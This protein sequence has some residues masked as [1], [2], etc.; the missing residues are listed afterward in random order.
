M[1]HVELTFD[2]L[3]EAVRRLPASQKEEILEDV[4]ND[5]LPAG[6]VK[7]ARKLRHKHRLTP[8]QQQRMN[9]LVAKRNEG[10]LSPEEQSELNDFVDE[11]DR[12]MVAMAEEM[13]RSNRSA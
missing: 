11:I 13:L 2:Q 4:V 10:T 9:R 1:P 8:R 5:S 3:R 12:R 7:L 6:V